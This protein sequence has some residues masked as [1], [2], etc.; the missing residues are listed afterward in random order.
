MVAEASDTE[1]LGL[2]ELI[3]GLRSELWEAAVEGGAEELRFDVGPITL[4]L[5]VMVTRAG[6]G[7]AGVKFWVLTASGG[8]SFETARTQRLQLQLTPK[9]AEGANYQVYDTGHD[10]PSQGEPGDSGDG[11]REPEPGS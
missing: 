6:K 7:D 10:L 5:E 4:D 9:T 1:R 8:G 11:K 2:V 3:R